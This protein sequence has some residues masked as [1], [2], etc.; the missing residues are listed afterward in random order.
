LV[1]AVGLLVGGLVGLGFG[2]VLLAFLAIP[3]AFGFRL[4]IGIV[5]LDF[6]R[7]LGIG[8]GFGCVH[9]GIVGLGIGF[10]A[11]GFVLGI[12]CLGCLGCVGIVVLAVFRPAIPRLALRL[13]D[14]GVSLLNLRRPDPR[15]DHRTVPTGVVALPLS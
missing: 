15:L 3:L 12:I 7:G 1:A 13:A 5:Y 4:G 14:L 9:L 6:L 2:L 10:R 11:F 8:F